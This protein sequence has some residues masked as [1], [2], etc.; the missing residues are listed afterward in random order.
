ML[1]NYNGICLF[2]KKSFKKKWSKDEKYCSLKCTYKHRKKIGLFKKEN[3]PRWR[4]LRL[5]N[6]GNELP[7]NNSKYCSEKCYGNAYHGK[8]RGKI[9]S[10]RIKEGLK[11][12]NQNGEKN[13]NWDGG[14]T[15]ERHKIQSSNEYKQWR[16]AVF[17]RDNYTCIQCGT[18]G[19]GQN[20]NADHIKSFAKYPKLR[21]K[22]SNG[23]TLCIK[24]HRKTKTYGVQA[25]WQ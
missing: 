5:C 24:C 3:H 8:S 20:L 6:C 17:K 22:V 1:G 16:K 2:C 18:K 9:H 21:L 4:G 23:R 25:K 19:Y 12:R 11:N 7:T 10:L 14:K 13:P 15:D